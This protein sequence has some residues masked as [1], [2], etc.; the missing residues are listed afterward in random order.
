ML[1]LQRKRMGNPTVLAAQY[2]CSL[3]GKDWPVFLISGPVEPW[4][5]SFLDLKLQESKGK[6]RPQSTSISYYGS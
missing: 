1:T 2:H 4:L 3:K 6:I 5:L